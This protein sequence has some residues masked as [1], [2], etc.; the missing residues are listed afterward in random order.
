[1]PTGTSGDIV[2]NFTGGTMIRAGIGVWSATDLGG[3]IDTSGDA[4]D[5]NADL[6]ST[7]TGS[8][9]AIAFYHLYDEGAFTSA[10]FSNATERYETVSSAWEGD[11]GQAGADY[12][13]TSSGSVSV[14]AT[15][16]DN[17]NDGAMVGAAFGRVGENQ[18]VA[19]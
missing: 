8:E 10:S 2:V 4:D 6:T 19:G 12:T 3:V 11:G 7:L 13:F 14:V 9:G 18:F 16:A 5:A 1:M 15:L 17:G